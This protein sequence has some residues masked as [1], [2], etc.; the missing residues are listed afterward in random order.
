MNSKEIKRIVET[1]IA[2]LLQ[3]IG[4]LLIEGPKLC[5]KTFLGQKYSQS[6]FYVENY[7]PN[8]TLA[9]Q[10]NWQTN[11]IFSG[12]QPRLIDE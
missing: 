11:I 6:Q 3:E 8:L 4:G 7:G 5:G 12:L 10:E 9:L 1:E 2:L